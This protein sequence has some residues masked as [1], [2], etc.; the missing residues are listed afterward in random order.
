MKKIII[1]I[2][3]IFLIFSFS[4]CYAAEMSFTDVKSTDWFYKNLQELVQKNIASGYP[5]GTFR[6]DNTLKFEE[7]IKMLVVA[8]GEETD[9][10][11]EGQEWYEIYI[12]KAESSNYIAEQQKV[13]IGQNIDRRA[14]AEIL[15]NVLT[16]KENIK[17]YT[18]AELQ[19]LSDRLTDINKNDINILTINGIGVISGYPDGTFKPAGTLT[20]AEAV[21]VISRVINSNMRNPISLPDTRTLDELPPVDLSH[22][23]AYPTLLG[24]S[25]VEENQYYYDRYDYRYAET[26]IS[27]YINY[28]ELMHNRDYTKIE[29]M[30]K[31]YSDKLIYYLNGRKEYRGKQYSGVRQINIENWTKRNDKEVL[32]Y[33]MNKDDYIEHFLKKWIQD[34]ADY[35]VQVKAAFYTEEGLL[36]DADGLSA[37]RGTLRIK[38]DNHNNPSNIKEELDLVQREAQERGK[39]ILGLDKSRYDIYI[40]YDNIPSFEVGKWYDIE[41]DVV[42]SSQAFVSGFPEEKAELSYDYIYPISIKLVK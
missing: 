30:D 36:H 11:E 16:E 17:V 38:Y 23:Y 42:A 15:Y 28:M 4:V 9:E 21:A 39:R 2:T 19:Y 6:P 7:F 25:M 41:M 14:M 24:T 13:L 1:I 8:T 40:S 34:T 3:A 26:A 22:L 29:K 27:D 5:D 31:G 18:D 37:I 20:R 10:L 32:D 35:K 12:K 33:I